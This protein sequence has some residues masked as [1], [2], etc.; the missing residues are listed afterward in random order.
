MAPT[1]DA[2]PD[3][4]V[5]EG[6]VVLLTGTFTDVEYADLH[7][8]TWN[9]GDRQ[10]TEAG[11]VVERNVP[12]RAE[13]TAS[14][15]HAWCDDGVY[16]V[17]L[18]VRDQNGGMA[19]DTRTVTVRNVPPVVDAGPDVFAY[20]CTVL[21]MTASFTDP[22]WCDTH[23]AR[24]DF[25]DC[26]TPIP[27]VIAETHEP[28]AGTGTAVASHIYRTCGTFLARCTVVDDDGGEGADTVVV[29]VTDVNNSDFEGGFARRTVGEV[30]NGWEPYVAQPSRA[31]GHHGGSPFVVRDGRRAQEVGVEPGQRAGICQRVG[32]NPGWVYQVTAEYDVDERGVATARLGVDP[33]GGSDPDAPSV[34]WS[35][36]PA[37]DRWTPLTVRV[38]AD[39]RAITV[40]LDATNPRARRDGKD[41]TEPVWFDH[42]ELLAIQPA[43]PPAEETRSPKE[44]CLELGG[45]EPD[46]EVPAEW[47][48]S[49]FS[50]RTLDGGPRRV[51]QLPDP[52]GRTA[53]VVGAGL[54]VGLPGEASAVRIMLVNAGGGPV[55]V[56]AMDAAGQGRDGYEVPSGT[57]AQPVTVTLRG[58]GVAGVLIDGEGA[59]GLLV[60]LCADREPTSPAPSSPPRSSLRTTP[61]GVRRRAHRP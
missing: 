43:C 4:E 9:F 33:S 28:P 12:P 16:E 31:S 15:R 7:E 30:A 50:I 18:R 37:R 39:A 25:G 27:A 6:E 23:T 49:G 51:V 60:R 17:T 53:L 45:R 48:E 56:I 29:R 42:V 1:V 54:A 61:S 10:P 44:E 14:V 59:E 26:S 20:P 40:F 11:D 34:V 24:W 2:G 22:G 8:A 46:S 3:I 47:E 38:T 19:T 55:R 32:A 5:D 35:S 13:G 41:A 21:T 36:S 57:D 52:P 58:P